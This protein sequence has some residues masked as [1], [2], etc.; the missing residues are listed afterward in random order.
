MQ[1]IDLT[2]HFLIAMPNMADER[3]S[4]TLTYICEHNEEGALGVI[5]NRPID[6]NMADLYTQLNVPLTH[7]DIANNPLYFGGPVD[8]GR[9]FVLHQPVGDWQSTLAVHDGVGLTTSKDVLEAWAEGH[10]PDKIMVS[11]GYAGWDAGQLE[12][13][14]AQ[15]AWLSVAADTHVLFD[16][17]ADE[18]LLAAM[19]LLGVDFANLSE[20]AG[21]A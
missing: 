10:G 2:G 5:V 11:L 12:N 1:T 7:P 8:A 16:L 14:M 6:M 19:R 13:E 18:R 20:E 17:P 4:R 9:G 15:N 3:F 21:H